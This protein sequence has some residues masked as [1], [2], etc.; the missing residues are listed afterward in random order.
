M[1]WRRCAN[2]WFEW[3]ADPLLWLDGLAVVMRVED[4]G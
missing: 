1:V 2:D 4:D 3:G